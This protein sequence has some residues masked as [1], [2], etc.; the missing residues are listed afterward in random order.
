MQKT[1]LLTFVTIF[2]CF[3]TFQSFECATR[4]SWKRNGAHRSE[5]GEKIQ[6]VQSAAFKTNKVN[7]SAE[8]VSNEIL[9][10]ESSQPTHVEGISSTETVLNNPNISESQQES[11]ATLP[12]DK[13]SAQKESDSI[14]SE[15]KAPENTTNFTVFEDEI[16]N[17]SIDNEAVNVTFS[18]QNLKDIFTGSK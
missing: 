3:T 16:A 4:K 9:T 15:I 2:L 7:E 5:N 14:E 17:V 18:E 1:V 8:I 6:L 12:S 10:E 13:N 11:A